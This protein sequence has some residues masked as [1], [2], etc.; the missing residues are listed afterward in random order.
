MTDKNIVIVGNVFISIT[1][2]SLIPFHFES[3]DHPSGMTET[4][5]F[6]QPRNMPSM[7]YIQV[8]PEL[9]WCEE[10]PSHHR[11]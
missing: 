7:P 5:L 10:L 1:T 4:I 6:T 3:H 8:G 2:P 9:A 11:P